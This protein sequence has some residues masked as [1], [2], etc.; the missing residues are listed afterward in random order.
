MGLYQEFFE[1][2]KDGGVDEISRFRTGNPLLAT[3]S[4]EKIITKIV[5]S[6]EKISFVSFCSAFEI[7]DGKIAQFF[8]TDPQNNN[9]RGI[10]REEIF[11]FTIACPENEEMGRWPWYIIRDNYNSQE[12]E[13]KKV[14]LSLVIL[15]TYGEK[16][17]IEQ[18]FKE[19]FDERNY[20][21]FTE[22]QV[23]KAKENAHRNLDEIKSSIEQEIKDRNG[24][25]ILINLTSWFWYS[26]QP[27][28]LAEQKQGKED[29]GNSQAII[30]ILGTDRNII[31]SSKPDYGLA[32][33]IK[34]PTT[35][36]SLS[37]AE[38]ID[39]IKVIS[40]VWYSQVAMNYLLNC[41]QDLEHFDA[42]RYVNDLMICYIDAKESDNYFSQDIKAIAELSNI[43]IDITRLKLVKRSYIDKYSIIDFLNSIFKL[44]KR[45]NTA[46][47]TWIR[48]DI[49]KV[50]LN[51][52]LHDLD[53]HNILVPSIE[54][55]DM[56]SC[57]KLTI[58]YKNSSQ[59]LSFTPRVLHNQTHYQQFSVKCEKILSLLGI[60]T[61]PETLSGTNNTFSIIFKP[62]NNRINDTEPVKSLE[63]EIAQIK[64]MLIEK[65]TK[66]SR[67]KNVG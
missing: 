14:P 49:L 33:G 52:L 17:G 2:I 47:E 23:T 56:D 10:S 67:L 59:L 46:Q 19:N 58:S 21:D 54:I 30:Y 8:S 64:Q 63:L 31:E 6:W 5:N 29:L 7:V 66:L 16:Q 62:L 36:G 50:A 61:S 35:G 13:A 25:P 34:S 43:F 42:I 12:N 65:E 28:I 11:N 32:I 53:T 51:L 37:S 60:E 55:V 20:I 38:L 9:S 4:M 22:E 39:C 27:T 48:K 1:F 40:S 44:P 18:L 15:P 24:D 3:K 26:L 41:S 57:V 45:A